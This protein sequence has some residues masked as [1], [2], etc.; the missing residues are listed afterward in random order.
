[1]GFCGMYETKEANSSRTNAREQG[2][3]PCKCVKRSW[4]P[5]KHV[6]QMVLALG[7]GPKASYLYYEPN[8]ASFSNSKDRFLVSWCV[9]VSV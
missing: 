2:L 3:L 9:C 5:V 7:L 8:N 1:M 6:M 4:V